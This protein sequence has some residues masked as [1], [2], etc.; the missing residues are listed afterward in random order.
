M[1]SPNVTTATA[2]VA[3]AANAVSAAAAPVSASP[4]STKA[5]AAKFLGVGL[6]GIAATAL[7]L[8]VSP[9][10]T[11]VLAWL[12][13][14]SFWTAIAIGMLLLVLIHHIFDASWSVVLRRQFEHG[15][16]SFKWLGLLF[17]PLL[18]ITW[19]QP[20]FIWD[21]TN[22]ASPLHGGHGTVG[23]DVLYIKK[24]G[25]L[26]TTMLTAM[27]VGFFLIWMWLSARLRKAS[28][29]QDSDG[30]V[31]WT[32]MNRT[33][34]AFGIPLV[35]LSLTGAAIYWMKSLEYHWFSTMY[36]VWFFANCARG[37][38][39]IGIVITLWLS[40]R[41][42]YQGILNKNHLHSIGQLMLAFTVFWAYVTFS[43]YFLIWN[44]N[45]PEETFWYNLREIN[46]SD[47]QPNQWKWVGMLL[48]F[49][50]FFGPFLALLSYR[51]KVTPHIIRR[52]A[53][54][55]LAIILVDL[56]YNILPA[57]K[58]AHGDPEPFLSMTL[59]WVVTAVI[60]VGGVCAW[61]YLRSFPS[62]KL[63]PIRDPRITECLTHHE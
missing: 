51:F 1:S 21:W 9:P 43:Q 52:I 57:L 19:M 13:G 28:F 49:G 17:A 6:I 47:G 27:S 25:F 32:T 26:N 16:A 42:D 36:G 7:G 24:A 39:S 33:T 50:H 14:V 37:A 53:Y 41:G 3:L 58:D 46:N 44:A 40:A 54:W 34:A 35:A 15:L 60:G 31:G 61:A 56:C 2:S 20:G 22:L 30:N 8:F 55:I 18:I 12:V 62:A 5:L 10:K 59:L 45:V 29:T 4:A 11:V 38:L 48:L 63:I 23:D